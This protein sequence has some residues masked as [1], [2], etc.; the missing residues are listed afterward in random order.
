MSSSLSIRA[1]AARD[2][3]AVVGLWEKCGL[4]VTQNDPGKDIARKR[5]AG[6]EWFFVGER[7]GVIVAT[8]MVGYDGHRGGVNYLAV[9][10]DHRGRGYG[11]LLMKKAEDVLE[12]AGCPKINLLVRTT[13]AE[14]ISFYKALGYGDNECVSLGKRLIAD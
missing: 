6:A 8:C 10:P 2:E 14:V 9:D 3:A 7:D 5:Q 1:F 4:V 12:E 11:K 13:N